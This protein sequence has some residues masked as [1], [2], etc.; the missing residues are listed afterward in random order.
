[1]FL[2]DTFVTLTGKSL[3]ITFIKH[4]SLM[5]NF[6]KAIIYIDPVNE[7]ADFHKMPK[8][9]Y[10]L[11]THE[12]Y[13]H[14]DKSAIEKVK[15]DKTKI[16]LNAASQKLLPIG[17]V[18]KNGE[19]LI[20]AED[21]KVEAVPSYNLLPEKQKFHPKGGRDNGYVLTLDGLRIYIAGDTEDIPEM[22]EI[23]NI[24]IA[25]L[26]INQ[27]YTMLPVQAIHATKILKPKILYPY[28][29]SDTKFDDSF[30]N[31]L[32]SVDVRMRGME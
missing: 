19:K 15:T 27:P 17:T 1:M 2:S 22:A 6:N 12:H 14:F 26:P 31:E 21:F 29:Y 9:D 3:I 28:H 18:L 7:F 16:V 24:D 20:L 32:K 30:F 23:K 10:I 4:A 25:F 13:D 11:I 5:L 8:A